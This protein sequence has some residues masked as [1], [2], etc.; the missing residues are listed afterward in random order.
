MPDDHGDDFN[1]S[2]VLTYGSLNAHLSPSD[3]DWFDIAEARAGDVLSTLGSTDTF[4]LLYDCDYLP[5]AGDDDGGIGLNF[6]LVVPEGA[7]YLE[8]RGYVSTI[9]GDYTLVLAAG[10]DTLDTGLASP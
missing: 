6:H 2:T 10:D 4:G 1:S 9:E 3:S 8:V 5:M 7:C